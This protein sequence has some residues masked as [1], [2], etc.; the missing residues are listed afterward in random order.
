LNELKEKYDKEKGEKEKSYNDLNNNYEEE[1]NKNKKLSDDIQKYLDEKNKNE[2]LIN[3]LKGKLSEKEKTV[4]D[5]T[6]NLEKEK[7]EKKELSEKNE[8]LNKE[9]EEFEKIKEENEK[10]SK[11]KEEFDKL[12][13]ENEKNKI[14]N[15]KF[16]NIGI[17]RIILEFD[18]NPILNDFKFYSLTNT[19]ILSNIQS[20]KCKTF[21]LNNSNID[22]DLTKDI[23]GYLVNNINNKG[24]RIFSDYL[25]LYDNMAYFCLI[26]EI[27]ADIYIIS[28]GPLFN[29]IK[30]ENDFKNNKLKK[31][32][33]LIKKKSK[34]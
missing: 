10:L 22:V 18:N 2:E 34:E 19:D 7:N 30:E 28:K 3:E 29:K 27:N 13:E 16:Y 8:K 31:L 15:N 14:N 23:Y 17:I 1:K 33:F 11:E 4:N 5:L 20:I 12:K 21:N 26:P 24:F 32:L 25:K 6:Q 9:K